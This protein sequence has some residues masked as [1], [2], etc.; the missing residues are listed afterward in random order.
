MVL[1]YALLD[2]YTNHRLGI[3]TRKHDK[4]QKKDSMSKKLDGNLF[5]T[6]RVINFFDKIDKSCR[7]GLE[8]VF[9]EFQ[10]FSN[11]VPV[12]G[13]VVAQPLVIGPDERNIF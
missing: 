13:M 2:A 4:L 3:M 10:D 1:C 12:V 7:V 9:C 11:P 5:K 6:D 8:S